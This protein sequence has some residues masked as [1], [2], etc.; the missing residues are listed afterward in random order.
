MH[1]F[2]RDARARYIRY[3]SAHHRPPRHDRSVARAG[4]GALL[5]PQVSPRDVMR[6]RNDL[7]PRIYCQERR[8]KYAEV[9]GARTKTGA[10]F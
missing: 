1:A 2:S 9:T 3:N 8:K 4:A 7:W 5:R 10:R 6:P